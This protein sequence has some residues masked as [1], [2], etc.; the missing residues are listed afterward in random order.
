MRTL[1]KH[2]RI[3]RE[4]RTQPETE[5]KFRGRFP[6]TGMVIVDNKSYAVRLAENPVVGET[7]NIGFPVRVLG[8]KD[9]TGGGVLIIAVRSA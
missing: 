6:F 3:R 9:V 2:A 7:I 1:S 8:V 5:T 4:R